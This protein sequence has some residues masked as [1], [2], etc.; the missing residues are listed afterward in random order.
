MPA[1][2]WNPPQLPLPDL[3]RRGSAPTNSDASRPVNPSRASSRPAR[4]PTNLVL[5]SGEWWAARNAY[6]DAL[7]P[8]GMSTR[9][10]LALELAAFDANSQDP[11]HYEARR[12]FVA[13]VGPHPFA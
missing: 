13:H 11:A 1:N 3:T 6:L 8:G 2:T 12:A 7:F 4:P 5:H 9:S 10:R